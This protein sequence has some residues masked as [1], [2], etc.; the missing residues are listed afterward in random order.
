LPSQPK[1]AHAHNRPRVT[2][3]AKR[4]FSVD[5]AATVNALWEHLGVR[6]GSSLADLYATPPD[7]V[8]YLDCPAPRGRTLEAGSISP[9]AQRPRDL[10]T[11]ALAE[12]ANAAGCLTIP[13]RI[14]SDEHRQNYASAPRIIEVLR[15]AQPWTFTRIDPNRC[16]T[17]GLYTRGEVAAGDYL[18]AT[19]GEPE[20]APVRIAG[21]I[22]TLPNTG[23]L[24]AVEAFAANAVTGTCSRCR[25]AWAA[26]D[27]QTELQ[28][29]GTPDP[30]WSLGDAAE[31]GRVT[32][33]VSCPVGDCTGRIWFSTSGS[34][35]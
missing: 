13:M 11:A 18:V 33:T 16:G 14:W 26:F 8:W 29:V 24:A 12:A 6:P 30:T 5:A 27:G 25:R 10:G 21:R 4:T 20:E 7:G 35:A 15:V 22:E 1:N 17:G 32:A 31:L 28:P 19:I 23:D 34:G 2:I 9:S 3:T